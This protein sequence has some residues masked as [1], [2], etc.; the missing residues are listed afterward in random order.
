MRVPRTSVKNLFSEPARIGSTVF[1]WLVAAEI[2][3]DR[4][5]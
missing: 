1:K 3:R 2:R 5:N 4:Y